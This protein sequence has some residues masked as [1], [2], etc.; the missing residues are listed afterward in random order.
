V[1]SRRFSQPAPGSRELIYSGANLTV[2]WARVAREPLTVELREGW[3][4]LAAC[5][6]APCTLTAG[7]ERHELS[8]KDMVCAAG[9]HTLRFEGEGCIVVLAVGRSGRGRML[10]VRRFSDIKPITS[11]MPGYRRD[12]YTVVG[13]DDPTDALMAGYTEGWPGEWTSF[14][15]HKHDDKVEVYVYYGL[16]G[17][18]GV[19]L[20]YDEEG[21]ECW[22]VRDYDAVLIRKGYH[23][24][25]PSPRARICYLW[26]LHQSF[27]EKNM[28][29][30]FHPDFKGWEIGATHLRT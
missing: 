22:L 11:G 18:F 25:V 28:R 4:M 5:L 21:E 8:P 3:E 12:V 15:P 9:P 6:K 30:Q 23:P 24:N 7:G 17:G 26:I 14:P 16:G 10:T 20:V 2:E 27:G 13:V 19:Q 1:L 29:V